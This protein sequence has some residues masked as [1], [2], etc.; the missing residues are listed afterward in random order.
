MDCNVEWTEHCIESIALVGL[1]R[2]SE[3][4]TSLIKNSVFHFL[5]WI[6]FGSVENCLIGTDRLFIL[7]PIR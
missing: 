7:W 3:K 1:T 2:K 5:V 6:S 4:H